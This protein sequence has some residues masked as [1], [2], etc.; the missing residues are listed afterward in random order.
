MAKAKAIKD[1]DFLFASARIK[2]IEKNL[3]SRDKLER[4]SDAKSLEDV[5]R[6]LNEFGWPEI[7]RPSMAAV[8]EVLASR[9]DEVFALI[10]KEN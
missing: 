5:L 7:T 3:L 6:L 4:L 9:R 10:R 2:C 1:T 8:E